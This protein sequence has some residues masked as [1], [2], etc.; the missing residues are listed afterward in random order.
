MGITLVNFIIA[1]YYYYY[2]YV[3]FLCTKENPIVDDKNI[4][5]QLLKHKVENI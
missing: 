2:Y 5:Q 4:T 3:K 1:Y